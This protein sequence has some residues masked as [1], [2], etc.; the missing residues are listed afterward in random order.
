M[1][2]IMLN[3]SKSTVSHSCHLGKTAALDSLACSLYV[4]S[5]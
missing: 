3:D 4:P 2:A 5:I 1:I